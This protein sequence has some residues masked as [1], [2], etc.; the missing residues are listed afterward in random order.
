[1]HLI[2]PNFSERSEVKALL[3]RREERREQ[4]ADG[5][6]SCPRPP[7]R[8]TADAWRVNARCVHAARHAAVRGRARGHE[9]R[10]SVA[11]ARATKRTAAKRNRRRAAHDGAPRRRA[12]TR[13]RTRCCRPRNARLSNR[14]VTF[15]NEMFFLSVSWQTLV[16]PGDFRLYWP[17]VVGAVWPKQTADSSV[18]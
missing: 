17:R 12:R 6:A 2:P 8:R 4:P 14:K 18:S 11:P 1:M 10:R 9:A 15:F 5:P 7:G 13:E 16:L 3:L